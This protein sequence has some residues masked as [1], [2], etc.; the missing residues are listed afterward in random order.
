MFN[1]TLIV[2]SIVLCTVFLTLINVFLGFCSC[3]CHY[4]LVNEPMSWSDAQKYCQGKYID[5]ATVDNTEDVSQ[6]MAAAGSFSGSVW[7]GLYDQSQSWEWSAP[8]GF[9]PVSFTIKWSSK[10]IY[11]RDQWELCG[12]QLNGACYEFYC[13]VSQPFVC[14]N[15]SQGGE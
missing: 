5:L 9:Q 1:V 4:I 2:K 8:G 14:Y 7:I 13:N 10:P 12:A 3:L 11:P 6:L 15:T